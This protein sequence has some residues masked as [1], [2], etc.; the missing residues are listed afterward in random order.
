MAEQPICPGEGGQVASLLPCH[1]LQHSP[2]FCLP[3]PPCGIGEA[4]PEGAGAGNA[5]GWLH[6]CMDFALPFGSRIHHLLEKTWQEP[7]VVAWR[8]WPIW[9]KG[10]TLQADVA[11]LPVFR[12][13]ISPLNALLNLPLSCS[14]FQ[15]SQV[16]VMGSPALLV[17]TR[18]AEQEGLLWRM[19]A[20]LAVEGVSVWA[21][22][23]WPR[24]F[25]EDGWQL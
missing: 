22:V 4:Q 16:I 5:Q 23:V 9:G 17:L 18:V 2:S 19:R 24:S 20:C 12:G 3:G 13:H 11:H 6:R 25:P 15:C 14:P 10:G 7:Q 1:P 8:S 21:G